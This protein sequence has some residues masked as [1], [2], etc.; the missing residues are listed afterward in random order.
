MKF[1]LPILFLFVLSKACI[2]QTTLETFFATE[3]MTVESWF[4]RPLTKDYK[5]GIFSLNDATIDY[6]SEEAN[7][8]SYTVVGYDIWKGFGPVL[9][10]RFFSSRASAMAGLQWSKS[11]ENLLIVSNF[12]TEI[13]NE[14]YYELFLLTQY[15]IPLNNHIGLF[16]QFQ[17]STNFNSKIH[18]FSF[19]RL[20][21]GLD[22]NIYQ[23]GLGS[24][25][26]QL[27]KD[28]NFESDFGFFIRLEF[29]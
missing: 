19:Q 13:R 23:F 26:Y 5:L 4:F 21:I 29:K 17:T 14:P 25:T 27:G 6:Q 18:D 2:A 28:R 16:S 24:N 11:N 9:G 8:V 22:W 3:E 7:F 1:F 20:R 15:R 12:T 10:S